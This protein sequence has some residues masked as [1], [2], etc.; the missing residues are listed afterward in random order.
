[1]RGSSVGEEVLPESLGK[2]LF[3]GLSHNAV[4]IAGGL[5]FLY[6]S[7]DGQ[8]VCFHRYVQ[9]SLNKPGEGEW[10]LNIR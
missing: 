5:H 8:S 3:F 9:I 4:G 1:M 6:N 2:G 7:V 10:S